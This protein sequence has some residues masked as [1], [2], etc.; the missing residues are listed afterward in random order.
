MMTIDSRWTLR[1]VAVPA[2]LLAAT[3]TP[4]QGRAVSSDRRD[5]LLRGRTAPVAGL[6]NPVGVGLGAITIPRG[7]LMI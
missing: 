2:H 6:G 4:F 7:T 1:S 3:G 5:A